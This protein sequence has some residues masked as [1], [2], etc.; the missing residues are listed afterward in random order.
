MAI[1]EQ[2]V[3]AQMRGEQTQRC[4]LNSLPAQ[5][6]LP[7]QPLCPAFTGTDA[8]SPAAVPHA[9]PHSA[10]EQRPRQ[11]MRPPTG[12]PA[13]LLD[14]GAPNGAAG[15]LLPASHSARHALCPPCTLH[16]AR[17]SVAAATDVGG[18]LLPRFFRPYRVEGI[19]GRQS[20]QWPFL[21]P[22]TPLPTRACRSPHT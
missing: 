16:P 8:A 4:S 15:C 17:P 6:R 18:R 20:A 3:R 1:G 22:H 14:R 12:A 5:R 19:A 11:A 21:L 13:H 7:R 9:C 2:G 10:T